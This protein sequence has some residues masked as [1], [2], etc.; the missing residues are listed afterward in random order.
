[1]I[2]FLAVLELMK[3]NEIIVEQE[4]NFSEIMIAA[5]EGAERVG[6]Y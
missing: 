2:T 4:D 1:M 6:S 5:K 3:L